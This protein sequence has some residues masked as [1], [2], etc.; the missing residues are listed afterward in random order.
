MYAKIL[1]NLFY[2]TL[3]ST[4]L[5]PYV[6]GATLYLYV[7]LPFLDGRFYRYLF[8]ALIPSR[9][10]VFFVFTVLAAAVAASPG[11]GARIVSLAIVVAYALMTYRD[12]DFYLYRYV[13]LNILL[14]IVQ[15]AFSYINPVIAYS[16]GPTNISRLLWGAY[17]G[18]SNT[19]FYEIFF[20]KRVSGLSREA[21]FFASLLTSTLIVL[22]CD[23]R[24]E[25]RRAILYILLGIGFMVSLSKMSLAVLLAVPIFVFRR[26]LS[27]LGVALF[28]VSLFAVAYLMLNSLYFSGG[29]FKE[30]RNVS[31]T[32]RA[33]G[34]VL[35][36]QMDVKDV[37]FGISPQAFGQKYDRNEIVIVLK[38]S[39]V[40]FD[41]PGWG[42][43]VIQFG[44]LA[45]LIGLC[46]LALLGMN[47]FYLSVLTLLTINISPL[48][49][50]AST[51]VAW[52]VVFLEMKNR[53][54]ENAVDKAVEDG[55]AL[56]VETAGNGA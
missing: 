39:L 46:Y 25:G 38:R 33:S 55:G 45:F 4:V 35:P 51:A 10:K 1:S 32:H 18:P 22:V 47:G 52:F 34:Y 42:G 7:L 14:A 44:L 27:K 29:K 50:T 17:A 11:L 20:L 54:A 3:T 40:D 36:M 5:S 24:M 41:I 48:A 31:I 26:G 12:G 6:G 9:V 19:N 23:R 15:F 28:F 13:V 30:D 16:I 43:L 8:S 53:A 2:L 49:V 37:L 21:G 56:P